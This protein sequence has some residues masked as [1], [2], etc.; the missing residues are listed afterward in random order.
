MRDPVEPG[1]KRRA[2]MYITRYM[3]QGLMKDLGR[4][5][6][7][8]VVIPSPIIDIAIDFVDIPLVQ[9]TKG[10]RIGLC[11]LDQNDF[12]CQLFHQDSLSGA[13]SVSHN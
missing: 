2:P 11:L 9:E 5:I 1:R 6:L 10:V 12:V 4:Q 8:I 7:G 3:S 13:P